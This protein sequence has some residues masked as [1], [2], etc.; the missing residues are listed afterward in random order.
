GSDVDIL[1]KFSEPIGWEVVDLKEYLESLLGKSVDL[2]TVN[3]LKP[4]LKEKI[5]AEVEYT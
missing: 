3:A 1:V 2:V 4:Q 5:L